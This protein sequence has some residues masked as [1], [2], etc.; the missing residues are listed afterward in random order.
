MSLLHGF[1]ILRSS[2]NVLSIMMLVLAFIVLLDSVREIIRHTLSVDRPNLAASPLS[3]LI[4]ERVLVILLRALKGGLALR[5]MN[6]DMPSI[7]GHGTSQDPTGQVLRYL[8]L[9]SVNLVMSSSRALKHLF[10]AG[11]LS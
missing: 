9:G 5:V 2:T 7:A 1:G 3:K 6:G 11:N 10:Y 8:R 4:I